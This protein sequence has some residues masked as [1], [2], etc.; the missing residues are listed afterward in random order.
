MTP[1]M[2]SRVAGARLSA[3]FHLLEQT[4]VESAAAMQRLRGDGVEHSLRDAATRRS[5]RLPASEPGLPTPRGDS[6]STPAPR[7]G[8]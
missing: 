5:R 6:S 1:V 3:R 4:A 7:R 2:T 8:E